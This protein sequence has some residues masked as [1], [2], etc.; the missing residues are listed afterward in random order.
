MTLHQWLILWLIWFSNRAP[1][2]GGGSTSNEEALRE[3]DTIEVIE[4][5]DDSSEIVKEAAET[6]GF[7]NIKT[8]GESASFYAAQTFAETHANNQAMN[9]LRIS[10]LAKATDAVMNLQPDEG[11][12]SAGI[13]GQLAK[14]LQ[15]TPPPTNIPTQGG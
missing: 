11:T 6:V 3:A 1:Q 9:Q 5:A 7:G 10:I 8:V 2:Y 4:M 13:L 15:Q 14:M 12:A